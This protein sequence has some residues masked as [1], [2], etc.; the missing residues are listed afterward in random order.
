LYI[1]SGNGL[2]ILKTRQPAGKAQPDVLK[3]KTMTKVEK[4]G[5]GQALRLAD[6]TE[7]IFSN[8]PEIAG[9]HDY[10][11]LGNLITITFLNGSGQFKVT[12]RVEMNDTVESVYSK[13][14]EGVSDHYD[15]EESAERWERENWESDFETQGQPFDSLTF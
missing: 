2:I 14:V 5:L 8:L 11:V 1:E 6:H 4:N 7:E 3:I 13:F 10:K 15:Q 9:E 12:V